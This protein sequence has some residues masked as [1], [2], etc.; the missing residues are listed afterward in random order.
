MKFCSF[1]F[2]FI[3]SGFI[4]HFSLPRGVAPMRPQ[5][6][7]WDFLRQSRAQRSPRIGHSPLGRSSHTVE[8]GQKRASR[9]SRGDAC[10]VVRW[11]GKIMGRRE[12]L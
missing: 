2:I 10:T 11:A 3:F 1:I 9:G 7:R 6:P 8:L 5:Q 4:K 12:M